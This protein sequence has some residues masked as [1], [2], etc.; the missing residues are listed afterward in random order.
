MFSIG[1]QPAI[2]SAPILKSLRKSQRRTAWWHYKVNSFK[3]VRGAYPSIGYIL[4]TKASLDQINIYEPNTLNVTSEIAIP[5]VII[6]SLVAVNP[7]RAVTPETVFVAT[8]KDN[9]HHFETSYLTEDFNIVEKHD[10]QSLS[11]LK[12]TTN[13]GTPYT[14]QSLIDYLWSIPFAAIGGLVQDTTLYPTSKPCNYFCRGR[15]VAD[16]LH[17]VLTDLGLTL[18]LD[19]DGSYHI[20]GLDTS[21][22]TYEDAFQEMKL[23]NIIREVRH[24]DTNFSEIPGRLAF[25]FPSR[26]YLSDNDHQ[27]FDS[28]FL[29]EPYYQQ[30]KTT[31]SP[32]YYATLDNNLTLPVY[33]NPVAFYSP[34]GGSDPVNKSEID[35]Y[36]DKV[37]DRYLRKMASNFG[38]VHTVAGLVP[39]YPGRSLAAVTWFINATESGQT[40]IPQTI[41]EVPESAAYNHRGPIFSSREG[42]PNYPRNAFSNYPQHKSLVVKPTSSIE[43]EKSGTATIINYQL[44]SDGTPKEVTSSDIEI[45]NLTNTTLKS[46][47]KYTADFQWE[48]QK[49]AVWPGAS[50]NTDNGGNPTTNT[51]ADTPVV[52]FRLLEDLSLGDGYADAQLININGDAIDFEGNVLGNPPPVLPWFPN[53]PYDVGDRCISPTDVFDTLPPFTDKLWSQGDT[54]RCKEFHVS[55]NI[56]DLFSGETLLWEKAPSMGTGKIV[57]V[58][59]S[60]Q[61]RFYGYGPYNVPI[62]GVEGGQ[63]VKGFTGECCHLGDPHGTDYAGTGL[64]GY[65]IINMEGPA[66]TV[67]GVVLAGG[68]GGQFYARITGWYGAAP[69]NRPPKLTTGGG[70]ETNE[71]L[72]INC[73]LDEDIPKADTKIRA[74]FDEQTGDWVLTDY[75][76]QQE[77]G[78]GDPGTPGQIILGKLKT[79]LTR[80]MGSVVVVVLSFTGDNPGTE[81]TAYNPEDL[82]DPT[83][84]FQGIFL[85]N[86][87]GRCTVL[88]TSTGYHLIEVQ[89]P[90]TIPSSIV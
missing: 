21:A 33:C 85:G 52:R 22:I 70:S 65:L 43:K 29:K 37:Q 89:T 23:Q 47:E 66:R 39:M 40:G 51:E 15:S 68:G 1:G 31:S 67:E 27:S 32:Y 53:T 74:D 34:Q 75:I 3:H 71:N 18:Y 25:C 63:N 69:N 11:Y 87:D 5:N 14:W 58:D 79:D 13:G 24:L 8:L 61:G 7:G 81:I 86:K 4:L 30:D 17:S 42:Y 20:R 60:E 6:D 49:W 83:N 62:T 41:L 78:G 16:V 55:S 9:R 38:P 72:L 57:V 56:F 73:R 76:V 26:K 19:T 28:R 36:I 12:A 64:P 46:T 90:R 2:N 44:N 50:T 35:S 82:L 59:P 77:D 45:L 10:R 88:S 84:G 48:T 54:I 80:L